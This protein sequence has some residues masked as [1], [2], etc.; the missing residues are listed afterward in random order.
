MSRIN[1]PNNP[2]LNDVYSFAD[3]SWSWNGRS[4]KSIST[5]VGFTGSQGDIGSVGFT[6]SRGE[7]GPAG[8]GEG[9]DTLLE[10]HYRRTNR[11]T[12]EPGF[13]KWYVPANSVI[14]SIKA[15]VEVASVGGD[16]GIVLAVRIYDT[17]LNTVTQTV[18]LTINNGEKESTLNTQE[19]IVLSTNYVVVDILNIGTTT[20]GENLTV[21]FTYI[22]S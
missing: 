1:F 14:N 20:A 13:E 12:V 17:A 7:R 5:F 15:R 8:D 16:T 19:V 18:T 22:R 2:S 4:W 11:L 10:R 6:G 9:A 21:T 3:R